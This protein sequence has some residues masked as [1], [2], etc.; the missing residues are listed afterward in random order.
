MSPILGINSPSLETSRHIVCM[1]EPSD[2]N[3][4]HPLDTV[5]VAMITAANKIKV[6][7][8]FNFLLIIKVIIL[9]D[10]TGNRDFPVS[11]SPIW[12]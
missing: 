10:L 3:T 6:P 11:L 8:L 7:F 5:D 4:P 12:V 9:Q 2:I 1:S